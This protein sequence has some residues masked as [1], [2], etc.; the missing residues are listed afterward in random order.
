METNT[1]GSSSMEMEP[2]LSE[3]DLKRQLDALSQGS[4][5][6]HEEMSQ[7]KHLDRLKRAAKTLQELIPIVNFKKVKQALN[8]SR[9]RFTKKH[10][11]EPA[12]NFDNNHNSKLL[13]QR[14]CPKCKFSGSFVWESPPVTVSLADNAINGFWLHGLPSSDSVVMCSLCATKSPLGEWSSPALTEKIPDFFSED[15]IVCCL[16]REKGHGRN[17]ITDLYKFR[18]KRGADGI[19]RWCIIKPALLKNIPSQAVAKQMARF[20]DLRFVKDSLRHREQVVTKESIAQN[21]MLDI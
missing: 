10:V 15:D 13:Y 19:V 7:Y 2:I 6:T 5:G 4:Q 11:L 1:F 17:W 3:N 14:E 8:E 21:A 9:A 18:A 12:D 16:R 20:L